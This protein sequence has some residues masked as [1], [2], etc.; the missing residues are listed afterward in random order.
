VKYVLAVYQGVVKEVY[1]TISWEP[2]NW[3]SY[4]YRLEELKERMSGS[5]RYRGRWQFNGKMAE[6]PIRSRY[7]GKDVSK[8]LVKGGQNPIQYVNC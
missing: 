7:L 3:K 8:Y 4:K 2:A 5:E 6:E 1:Q